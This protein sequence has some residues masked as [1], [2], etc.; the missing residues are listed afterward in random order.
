MNS[1][2]VGFSTGLPP[3]RTSIPILSKSAFR[4]NWIQPASQAQSSNSVE[5]NVTGL[6]PVTTSNPILSKSAFRQGWIQP[7]SQIQSCRNRPFDWIG[8]SQGLKSTPVEI[9]FSTGLDPVRASNPIPSKSAPRHNWILPGSLISFC[10]NR[11]FDRI[12]SSR[13][14][15]SNSVGIGFPTELD[16]SSQDLK[17]NSVE[18]GFSIGLAP[19]RMSNPLLSKS[20]PRRV[21]SSQGLKSNSVEVGF[22]TGL[23]PARTPNP[24]LSKSA[25][26]Q[27][28]IQPGSHTQLNSVEIG[29]STE[30]DQ[31]RTSNPN[32]SKSAFRQNWTLPGS[33]IQLCR[34]RLFDRIGPSQDLKSTPVKVGFSTGLDPARTSN[35]ILSK[36]AFR[37]GWI[38][39]GPQSQFCRSQSVC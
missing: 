36:S 24:I 4:R 12:A 15:K 22:P 26:R 18:I 33:Q 19:V 38:Q 25:P 31:V 10:R 35:P 2:E 28:W 8:S 1:V 17:S 20:A 11:L 6:F 14:L 5:E 13:D 29:S 37:L 34:N 7:G 27:D 16:D 3:V 30:L 32:L 23:D 21:G 9:G 39:P